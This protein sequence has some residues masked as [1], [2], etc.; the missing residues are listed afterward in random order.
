MKNTLY[1]G[2]FLLLIASSCKK[3][4]TPEATVGSLTL[5]FQNL[6]GTDTFHLDSSYVHPITLDT[7]KFTTYN[8]YISNFKLQTT[9]G[10]WV[11]IPNAYMLIK[12]GTPGS[13]SMQFANV[14][15]G[16]YQAISIL[17]GVDSLHNVSG[18]QSGVLAPSEGMFWSWNTG[19]IMAKSEGLSPQSSSGEFAFHLGGFSGTYSVIHERIFSF[20]GNTLKI[21]SS[22]A[23]K[24]QMNANVAAM[25][26][27]TPGLATSFNVQSVGTK[28]KSMAESFTLGWAFSSLQN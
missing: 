27:Q 28:S 12:Q 19:Y 2:L 13:E 3:D 23:P 14:P 25:F 16:E 20:N 10:N 21:T 22:S 9:S 5:K 26:D 15:A 7:M 11:S 17:F 6:W 1:L 4:D 8:Y 24:I 18:A